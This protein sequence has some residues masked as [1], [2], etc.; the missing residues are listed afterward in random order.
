LTLRH[1]CGL[2]LLA[3]PADALEAA[4]VDDEAVSRVLNMARRSFRYVIVD[5]FPIVYTVLMTALDLTDL[6]FIVVQGTAPAVAGAARLL[7]MVDGLGL[8]AARQRLVLNYNYRP[9]LGDLRPADIGERLRRTIDHVIPYEKRVLVSMNTGVPEVLRANRWQ[10]FGRAI[11]LIVDEVSTLAL[12]AP[13][14]GA[15]AAVDPRVKPAAA[16]TA[17]ARPVRQGPERLA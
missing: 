5:T 16:V 13:A 8:S 4:E 11:A 12:D 9:F 14:A 3:A 17:D 10:R 7:P 2:R 6:A 1:P 15:A